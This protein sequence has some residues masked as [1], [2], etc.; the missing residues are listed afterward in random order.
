M[1]LSAAAAGAEGF[2]VRVS[3]RVACMQ[4]VCALTSTAWTWLGE[5]VL[6]WVAVLFGAQ[7]FG[8]RVHVITVPAVGSLGHAWP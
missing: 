7:V 1:S 3:L 4:W 2:A 6:L 8:Y 5:R